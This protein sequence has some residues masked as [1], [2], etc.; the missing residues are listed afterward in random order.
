MNDIDGF[1]ERIRYVSFDDVYI[2]EI[3]SEKDAVKTGTSFLS[4]DFGLE[5]DVD[6]IALFPASAQTPLGL[7]MKDVSRVL[8]RVTGSKSPVYFHLCEGVASNNKDITF[9]VGK[10]LSYL[11]TCFVKGGTRL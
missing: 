2:R 4:D 3:L 6:S 10:A 11:T 5:L 1:S 8:C 9:H 7:S